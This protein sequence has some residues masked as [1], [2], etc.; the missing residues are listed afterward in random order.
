M[1][2]P[3]TTPFAF[4][5]APAPLPPV[6]VMNDTGPVELDS[7]LL[8]VDAPA[9]TR[10]V[11]YL[12]VSSKGQ[13]T[14]DYDPEGISIPA[15]RQSCQRKAEQLGLTVVAEYVEA[16]ISGTEMTKRVAFQILFMKWRYPSILSS[17]SRISRPMA[18]KAM[19]VKRNES[20][21]YVPI[22]SSGSI[23]LPVDLDIFLPWASRTRACR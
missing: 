12:R 11:V 8:S 13:V 20:V 10:A 3:E 18:A 22:I 15:Q 14:T 19:R 21:P 4:T 5:G 6:E 16:G 9:G 7:P 23:T 2:M 17:E 1:S